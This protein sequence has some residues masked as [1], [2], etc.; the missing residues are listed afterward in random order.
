MLKAI[1]R[2][3]NANNNEKITN[4]AKVKRN[5]MDGDVFAL[6]KGAIS[7]NAIKITCHSAW[8]STEQK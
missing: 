5:R 7:Q 6:A 4:I 8:L 1:D 3:N 2:R